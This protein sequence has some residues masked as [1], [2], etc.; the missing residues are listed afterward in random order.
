MPAR[1]STPARPPA[2]QSATSGSH[3][4]PA[5]TSSGGALAAPTPRVSD[6]HHGAREALV[7]DHDVRSA[8]E[9]EQRLAGAVG[10]EHGVDDGLLG[11]GLDVAGGGAAQAQGRQVAQAHGASG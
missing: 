7:G 1:H 11:G 3:G 6:P 2:T 8:G 4:S 5:A 9:H 10:L